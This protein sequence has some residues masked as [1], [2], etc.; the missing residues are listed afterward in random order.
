MSPNR[1]LDK[2]MAQAMGY[3]VMKVE[4]THY[5]CLMKP[6]RRTTALGS[7]RGDGP[8]SLVPRKATR[9]SSLNEN[10]AWE[11]VPHFTTNQKHSDEL[12]NHM[13]LICNVPMPNTVLSLVELVEYYI[14][15]LNNWLK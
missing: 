12:S 6:H 8:K 14:E 5:F 15:K 13:Y 11:W 3:Y 4:G 2:K 7:L 9:S 10:D 1:N